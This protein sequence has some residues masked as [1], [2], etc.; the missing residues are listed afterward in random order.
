M[1]ANLSISA[2]RMFVKALNESDHYGTCKIHDESHANGEEVWAEA[3][4]TAIHITNRVPCATY[5]DKTPYEMCFGIKPSVTY[6]RVFGARGFN[7]IEKSTRMKLDKK[8]VK[9]MFLGCLDNMKGSRVWNFE[10]EKIE[11]TRSAQFQ[12]LSET[13][14]VQVFIGDKTS[15]QSRTDCQCDEITEQVP[16][17]TNPLVECMD[18]DPTEDQATANDDYELTNS[19]SQDK[20]SLNTYQS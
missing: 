18:V 1:V 6:L 16:I 12:E 11:I 2:L 20:R 10:S 4:N 9:G 3:M 19:S 8:A 7:R 17:T 13:I 15:G 5:P 14:H